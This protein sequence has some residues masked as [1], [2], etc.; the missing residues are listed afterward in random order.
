[1]QRRHERE[2]A[3]YLDTLPHAR[4][5]RAVGEVAARTGIVV[6][7]VG[8]MVR[9]AL[10]GYMTTDL[11]FVT[12]GADS[13][14]RLAK[15]VSKRFGGRT[16]H[17]YERFGT[18]AVRL[19]DREVGE[20]LLEFVAARKE[21][22]RSA[23]RNPRVASATL[24]EDL[25]RRDFTVNAM[26]ACLLPDRYGEL[27]DPFGGRD[28]LAEERLYT[29]RAPQKTFADDPLRMIRAVRFATQ[30]NFDIDG[31]LM[32]AMRTEAPRLKILSQERITGELTRIMESD[33]PAFGFALMDG[34]GLLEYILPELAALKGVERVA[35]REHKENF[36]HTLQVLDNV[37]EA[38]LAEPPENW[39]WL[40]WAAL[41]HDIGKAHTKRFVNGTG[42]TFHGHE[43]YGA[44]RMIPKL[45]RKLK[46]PL[47]ER[48]EY[49]QRLVALHHRPMALV[50]DTVTDSA[51]RR[52]LFDAGPLID[53]L[54]ILVRADV[55]SRN[56]RR[57]SRYLRAFDNVEVK[58]ADIEAKDHL[59]NFR[60]PI[61][62]LE[63]MERAGIRAGM[64]VGFIKNTIQEAILDGDIP[65]EHG[66]AVA[67]LME[68]KDD[69]VRREKLYRETVQKLSPRERTAMSAMREAILFEE[70]PESNEAAQAHI[71][72]IKERVLADNPS[73]LE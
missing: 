61:D 44:K 39:Y 18:A 27:I 23:S 72:A 8:G 45:F 55:T 54:M 15:A 50:D 20:I 14:I 33:A 30:L 58:F 31:S 43:Y 48:M 7:A 17:V 29:P 65:N 64:A 10:L 9:D 47:D 21:N 60:P 2:V 46:L 13:G 71:Q 41:L 16:V 63:I 51:V 11:D 69:A 57:R 68:I 53:D 19:R 25:A 6:Y 5:V 28:H 34:T 70:L 35:G 32:Q 62:G 59:R 26:A 52:L 37:V 40:R 42:W 73:S 56:P 38:T 67:L 4:W 36:H 12:E 49:V 3:Q 1:M 22:Y 24:L 66:A